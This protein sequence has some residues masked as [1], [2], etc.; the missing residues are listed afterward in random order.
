MGDA[1]EMERRSDWS[2]ERDGNKL[3]R[4]DHSERSRWDAQEQERDGYRTDR[5]YDREAA[6]GI[7]L[8][9]PPDR[10][11]HR[12]DRSSNER[13]GNWSDRSSYG[14]KYDKSRERSGN[15]TD[16]SHR[17][18]GNSLDRSQERR[19]GSETVRSN[20]IRFDNLQH[21]GSGRKGSKHQSD[22]RSQERNDSRFD[23]LQVENE[24]SRNPVWS[25]FGND[26]SP[27]SPRSMNA[28]P[29]NSLQALEAFGHSG[30][31]HEE[32]YTSHDRNSRYVGSKAVYFFDIS[33]N[34]VNAM[35]CC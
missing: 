21:D 11:R 12:S 13:D 20:D 29:K 8:E 27:I 32:Q 17:R 25:S 1:S 9:N 31:R 23:M 24:E 30:E 10:S 15:I 19:G 22:Y 2:Q 5:S 35:V 14:N 26:K 34:R 28:S 6:G 33:K 18:E 16:R 3:D 7:M 4:S